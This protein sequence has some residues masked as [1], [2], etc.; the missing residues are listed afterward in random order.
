MKFWNSPAG[1]V[2]KLPIALVVMLLIAWG[3]SE[4]L[5]SLAE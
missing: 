2:L 5:A 4:I 3:A 1:I